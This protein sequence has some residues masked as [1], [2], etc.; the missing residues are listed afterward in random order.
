MRRRPYPAQAAA[1]R[2]LGERARAGLSLGQARDA[3][4]QAEAHLLR[5]EALLREHLAAHAER[6]AGAPE[7]DSWLESGRDLAWRGAFA[8]R[9]SREAARLRQ[10]CARAREEVVLAD[11]A[12][13][14]AQARLASARGEE[15]AVE[16]HRGNY[17][18]RQRHEQ[19]RAEDEERDEL[20]GRGPRRG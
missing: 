9:Q 3:L 16:R 15:L 10:A 14:R 20:P 2:L 8:L 17:E 5:R 12:V 13:R 11:G 6:G 4:A 7:H 18:A 19:A 1:T